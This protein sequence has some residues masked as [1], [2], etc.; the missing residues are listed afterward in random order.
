MTAPTLQPIEIFKPGRHQASSGQVVSFTESHLAQAARVYSPE[1]HRA[2]LV[3]GHPKTDDVA[4]GHV[5]ALSYS[6]ATARLVAEPADV[7]PQFAELVADGRLLAVSASFYPPGHP[8]NP[9]GDSYY[10][11]HVGFL[12]AEAPAVK[13]LK[14]PSVAF[15]EHEDGVIEFS[16][17]TVGTTAGLFRSLRDWLIGQFGTE[18]ADKA[19]PSWSVQSLADEAVRALT[20]APTPETQAAGLSY[21]ERKTEVTDKTKEELDAREAE[22]NRRQAEIDKRDRETAQAARL[23]EFREFLGGLV[24]DG[25]RVLPVQAEALAAVMAQLP[26]ATVVEFAE[27]PGSDKLV[28]K[29]AV[30]VLKDFLQALP[31]N[32]DFTERASGDKRLDADDDGAQLGEV[33]EGV[34]IAKAAVEFQDAEEKAGRTVSLEAAVQHVSNQRKG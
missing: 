21:S 27:A 10:L 18:Q 2:P 34:S 20:P 28:S 25:C 16:D 14:R 3:V 24:K 4:Y 9:V 1:L 7:E 31:K 33:A 6:D 15:A 11:R 30:Q 5:A 17:W 32:V 23:A 26:A 22:L 29:P 13:G 19:L 8:A 12:G